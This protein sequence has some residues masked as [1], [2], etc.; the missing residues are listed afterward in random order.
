MVLDSSS[1][2]GI[3]HVVVRLV[4]ACALVNTC[5]RSLDSNAG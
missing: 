3:T 2:L 4:V 5:K 1:D